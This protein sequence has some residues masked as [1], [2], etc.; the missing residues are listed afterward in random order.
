V[1]VIAITRAI[2][3][4]V[5]WVAGV[6]ILASIHAPP[7]RWFGLLAEEGA[8]GIAGLTFC[9]LAVFTTEDRALWRARVN[10]L[11]KRAS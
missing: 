7:F 10:S 6:W 1:I 11:L 9:W 2:A 4:G 5:P 3:F 8:V